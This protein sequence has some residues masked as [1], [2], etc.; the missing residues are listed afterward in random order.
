MTAIS[1]KTSNTPTTELTPPTLG[2]VRLP[3]PGFARL[4]RA[5]QAQAAALALTRDLGVADGLRI[6]AL[7]VAGSPDHAAVAYCKVGDTAA[8]LSYTT[9]LLSLMQPCVIFWVDAP[10]GY[11]VGESG[12]AAVES[13][14]HGDNALPSVVAATIGAVSP[15]GTARC[16]LVNRDCAA[17]TNETLS[18]WRAASGIDIVDGTLPHTVAIDLVEPPRAQVSLNSTPLDRALHWCVAGAVACALFA[19]IDF[20]LTPRPVAIPPVASTAVQG[21]GAL[22]ERISTIAPDVPAA[23]QSATFAGGAW[24]L[25][26]ADSVDAAALLRATKLLEANGFAVQSTRLPSPRLRVALP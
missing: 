18:F 9:R 16:V 24:V 15:S 5:E 4:T 14:G 11:V 3:V 2:V 13:T 19:G 25:V 8:N 10:L 12:A 21:P 17:L 23:M 1:P 22:F 6:A 7:P 20:A 26:L